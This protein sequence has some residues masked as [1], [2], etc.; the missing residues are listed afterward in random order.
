MTS[1]R[2]RLNDEYDE[3]TCRASARSLCA[4]DVP[5]YHVYA[6]LYNEADCHVLKAIV[7]QMKG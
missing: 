4:D 2:R 7:Y 3:D 1:F 5:E 6:E